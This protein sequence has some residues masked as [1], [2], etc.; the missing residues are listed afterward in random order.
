MILRRNKGTIKTLALSALAAFFV[1]SVLFLLMK[2]LITKDFIETDARKSK[3]IPTIIQQKEVIE[4][5]LRQVKI[6]EVEEAEP[7]PPDV[8]IQQEDT[9]K[10][11][12][13]S[14]NSYGGKG[15]KF[16]GPDFVQG[17]ADGDLISVTIVQPQYP[18]RASERGIEGYVVIVF[19]VEKDGTT[20]KHRVVEN[21]RLLSDGTYKPGSGGVFDRAAL[22]AAQRLKYKPRVVDGKPVVVLDYYYK[23][24]FQLTE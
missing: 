13:N 19:N 10:I 9:D 12:I 17:F 15:F 7:P 14:S 4:K 24:T 8:E 20:S 5:Q 18:S 11:N 2:T 23:F 1:V 22:K 16:Q 21:A 6:E 3:P